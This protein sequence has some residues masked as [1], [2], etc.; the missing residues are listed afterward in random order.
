M[1]TSKSKRSKRSL[2]PPSETL[3]P[4]RL[5]VRTSNIILECM[6]R[7]Q[8]P[9]Y[10]TPEEIEEATQHHEL[11]RSQVN[12]LLPIMKECLKPAEYEAMCLHYLEGKSYRQIGRIMDRNA[13]TALRYVQRSIKKLRKLLGSSGDGEIKLP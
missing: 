2:N 11:C 10:E 7:A 3:P 13:S 8:T 4:M 1:N 5:G 9:W 12:I 6:D